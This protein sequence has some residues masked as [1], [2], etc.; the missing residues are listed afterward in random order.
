MSFFVLLFLLPLFCNGLVAFEYYTTSSCS[1]LQYPRLY[2]QTGNF[3]SPYFVPL[4]GVCTFCGVASGAVRYTQVDPIK[5]VTRCTFLGTPSPSGSPCDLPQGTCDTVP[6]GQCTNIGCGQGGAAWGKFVEI[7]ENLGLAIVALGSNEQERVTMDPCHNSDNLKK[8]SIYPRFWYYS[9]KDIPCSTTSDCI[10]L[11]TLT[12][13][14]GQIS[15]CEPSFS[16]TC[17]VNKTCANAG[18]CYTMGDVNQCAT[19][20]YRPSSTT[21]IIPNSDLGVVVARLPFYMGSTTNWT[22]GGTAAKHGV[23]SV[24]I[25]LLL[26]V[27]QI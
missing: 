1:T 15:Y 27:A 2:G 10:N 12:T 14:A 6:L 25:L 16:S 26:M 17:T 7:N 19:K 4:Q 18:T 22:T 5:G 11:P 21:P 9:P 8:I 13:S 20:F 24:F 3:T 23:A